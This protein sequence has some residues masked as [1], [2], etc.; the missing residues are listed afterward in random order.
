MILGATLEVV[1]KILERNWKSSQLL[2]WTMQWK[3]PEAWAK[4]KA[5]LLLRR[6]YTRTWAKLQH[7]R[8]AADRP[9]GLDVVGLFARRSNCLMVHFAWLVVLLGLPKYVVLDYDWCL[10]GASSD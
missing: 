10:H 6:W 4:P 7:S 2:L 1:S 5:P 3:C 9:V 8:P